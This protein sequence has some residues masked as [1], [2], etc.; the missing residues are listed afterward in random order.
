MK[1]L[2]TIKVEEVG[3]EICNGIEYTNDDCTQ[4]YNYS[5]EYK[6]QYTNHIKVEKLQEIVQKV[7]GKE[8]HWC[9][10]GFESHETGATKATA[11][12]M[13]DCVLGEQQEGEIK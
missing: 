7:F 12:R 13:L 1:I 8:W 6:G 2:E 3:F 4:H 5:G 10:C 9:W 11:K